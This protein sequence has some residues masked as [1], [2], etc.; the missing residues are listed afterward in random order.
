M[1]LLT[2]PQGST[3][4]ELRVWHLPPPSLSAHMLF[5]PSQMPLPPLLP[6]FLELVKINPLLVLSPYV[7][8]ARYILK[9]CVVIRFQEVMGINTCI[10]LAKFKQKLPVR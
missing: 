6:T 1:L 7:T 8:L 9:V 3:H 4:E 5:L 2:V 10:Q